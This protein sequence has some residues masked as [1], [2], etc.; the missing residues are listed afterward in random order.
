MRPWVHRV[1]HLREAARERSAAEHRVAR[2][3]AALL[4]AGSPATR[5]LE[6]SP[7]RRRREITH[8]RHHQRQL[9]R[10][11][12]CRELPRSRSPHAPA[13]PHHHAGPQALDS[14]VPGRRESRTSCLPTASAFL[15]RTKHESRAVDPL[16]RPKSEFASSPTRNIPS[17][18]QISIC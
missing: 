6:C 9:G 11:A 12:H 5:Q 7:A 17:F 14:R 15:S 3:P 2:P 13:R 1:V 16:L 18:R 8:G 10:P 4:P